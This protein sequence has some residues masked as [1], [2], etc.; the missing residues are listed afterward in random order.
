LIYI[1]SPYKGA[2]FNGD[3]A[4]RGKRLKENRFQPFEFMSAERTGG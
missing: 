4:D 1:L 2:L 3:M